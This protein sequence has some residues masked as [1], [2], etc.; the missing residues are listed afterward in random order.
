[1]LFRLAVN[2]LISLLLIASSITNVLANT[3]DDYFEQGVIA[4]R[5][6][7]NQGAVRAFE[8]AKRAG[9]TSS[10]LY[11]NLGVIYY[12]MKVYAWSSEYFK[13]LT[14]D[15]DYAALAYYNLG[16]IAASKDQLSQAV[17]DFNISYSLTH[18]PKLKALSEL[19]LRRIGKATQS[20]AYMD[21]D[22][23]KHTAGETNESDWRGLVSLTYARDDN[24]GLDNDEIK[25]VTGISQKH[26]NYAD[27]LA[28]THGYLYGNRKGGFS[29]TA[30]ANVQ[31]YSTAS[32]SRNYD[33]SQYHIALSRESGDRF[34]RFRYG[35]GYDQTW[36][37]GA[38]FLKLYSVDF[39]GK[40]ILDNRKYVRFHFIS[41]KITAIP[42]YQYL[43]GYKHLVKFDITV[44]GKWW[45]YRIGYSAELS[46]RQN[47][48]STTTY[49]YR[50]FSPLQNTLQAIGYFYFAKS[51]ETRFEL[52]YRNSIYRQEDMLDTRTNTGFYRKDNRY[53]FSAS[54][55]YNFTR[56]WQASL[57]FSYTK[58]DSNRINS[59][60][61]QLSDYQ[62]SLVSASVAWFY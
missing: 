7:D 26:D 19:A 56:R 30:Y 59:T 41:Y 45:K 8:N 52:Q 48:Q 13:K 2:L 36:F 61:T 25:Y 51:W 5:N 33:Y 10:A 57:D 39:S 27:I 50:S 58:N 37:G 32:I 62:R 21:Q 9:L 54:L 35:F 6:G 11:Y 3:A 14:N 46:N 20:I 40:R 1:M 4:A 18:D 31:K 12:R 16:L 34:W 29:L 55:I 42:L 43:D 17:R 15:S 60:G 47:F 44:P 49:T 53:L 38:D 22:N 24:V 28:T 23:L